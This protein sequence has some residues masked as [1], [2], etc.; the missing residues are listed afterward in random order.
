MEIALA[1]GELTKACGVRAY[2]CWRWAASGRPEG[3]V[4]VCEESL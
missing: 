1:S 4:S 2:L 3:G